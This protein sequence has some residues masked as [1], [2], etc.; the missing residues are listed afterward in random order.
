MES[1]GK[2]NMIQISSSTQKLLT[3][4]WKYENGQILDLGRMGVVE[5]FFLDPCKFY[6]ILFFV[7][8]YFFFITKF[9]SQ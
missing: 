8:F 6:F 9:Y 5:T 7:R 1:T 4:D 3:L 2:P